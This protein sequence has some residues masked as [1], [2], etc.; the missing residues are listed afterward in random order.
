MEACG[1][2][3]FASGKVLSAMWNEE[4]VQRSKVFHYEKLHAAS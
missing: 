2:G 4:V 3:D 1:S